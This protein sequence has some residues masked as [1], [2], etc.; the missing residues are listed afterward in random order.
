[1]KNKNWWNL[2]KGGKGGILVSLGNAEACK[3][4]YYIEDIGADK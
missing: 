3:E 1:M 2:I 4:A